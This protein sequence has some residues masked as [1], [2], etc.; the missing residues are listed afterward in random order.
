MNKRQLYDVLENLADQNK[1]LEPTDPVYGLCRDLFSRLGLIAK[2]DPNDPERTAIALYNY[3]AEGKDNRQNVDR[4]INEIVGEIQENP[5]EDENLGSRSLNS[6]DLKVLLAEYDEHRALT[7]AARLKKIEE[8]PKLKNVAREQIR[9]AIETKTRLEA[10]ALERGASPMAAD[11]QSDQ[12][13]LAQERISE[14]AAVDNLGEDQRWQTASEVVRLAYEAKD[15]EEALA[16]AAKDRGLDIVSD[17]EELS[18]MVEEVRATIRT[19]ERVTSIAQS[20][21]DELEQHGVALTDDKR[22]RIVA[23]AKGSVEKIVLEDPQKKI[24]DP[25]V[26]IIVEDQGLAHIVIDEPLTSKIGV[27]IG[28]RQMEEAKTTVGIALTGAEKAATDLFKPGA[29]STDVAGAKLNQISNSLL[30][31]GFNR[32]DMEALRAMRFATT[33]DGPK[34][35]VEQEASVI[36]EIQATEVARS[37]GFTENQATKSSQE[38]S[39]VTSL[40]KSSKTVKENIR[41]VII[42]REKLE[43]IKEL[44]PA[45]DTVTKISRD[46]R[47]INSVEMIRKL[48]HWQERLD[49]LTGGL[50]TKITGGAAKSIG[51]TLGLEGLKEYGIQIATR[52]G[53]NMM[54]AM[55]THIAQFGFEQGL[56]NILGQLLT[57]GTVTAVQAGTQIAGAATTAGAVA[58]DG[59]AAAAAG[60]GVGIPIALILVAIQL[61]LIL[62]KSLLKNGEKALVKIM[63]T[64]GIGSAKNVADAKKFIGDMVKAG[65]V[66]G[67]VIITTI[68]SLPA[69]LAAAPMAMVGIVFVIVFSSLIGYNLLQTATTQISS[70]VSPKMDEGGGVCVKKSDINGPAG[71]KLANCDSGKTASVPGISQDAFVNL[72]ERWSAGGGTNAARCYG[73]VVCAALAAGK[74]PTFVLWAWLHESGASNYNLGQIEDFGIHGQGPATNDFNAQIGSFLNLN[75]GYCHEQNGMDY[76]LGFATNYLTGTCDPNVAVGSNTGYTYLAEMQQT[77]SW[78]SG[79]PM[80][81]TANGSGGATCGGGSSGGGDD[82]EDGGTQIDPDTGEEYMCFGGGTLTSGSGPGFPRGTGSP[83]RGPSSPFPTRDPNVTIPPG[84]PMGWPVGPN[85]PITQGSRG[86]HTHTNIPGVAIDIMPTDASGNGTIGGTSISVTHPG[87]V[88][89]SGYS[90]GAYGNL[91]IVRGKCGNSNFVTY[92]A[93]LMDSQ[94]VSMNQTLAMGQSVGLADNSGDY[95]VGNDHLHYE[96][97]GCSGESGGCYGA[98]GFNPHDYLPVDVPDGCFWNCNVNTSQK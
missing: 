52:Y 54:G 27:I 72:A 85:M 50:I 39:V 48:V 34:A 88:V 64:L 18:R 68:L 32:A 84:C 65:M 3:E 9:R 83:S 41:I 79:K 8:S 29:A 43:G 38:A 98:S 66:A 74:D 63:E 94:L 92:Y 5:V 62:G 46:P 81:A 40:L 60:T 36:A 90:G 59:A 7:E 35:V 53:G 45:V 61:V 37:K 96:I 17:K 25:V 86:D 23:A 47:L 55:A 19:E 11:I 95:P 4:I 58:V 20:L 6:Q 42:N 70:Q 87:V 97:R 15:T 21:A 10:E 91:V 16:A 57:K 2:F 76:W 30:K 93:H 82:E 67:G 33:S 26:E 13:I 49:K 75:P 69:M 1:I 22:N 73:A 28:P 78:V 56:R 44:K 71:G 24:D 14:I 12:I 89:Y 80:P 31:K 51:N 77:W